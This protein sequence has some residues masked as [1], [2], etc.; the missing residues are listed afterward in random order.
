MT[1][2]RETGR[3]CLGAAESLKHV[4]CCARSL[5]SEI[6]KRAPDRSWRLHVCIDQNNVWWI[7]TWMLGV[8]RGG[9]FLYWRQKSSGKMAQHPP[10]ENTCAL[11]QLYML[12]VTWAEWNHSLVLMADNLSIR[13]A[14]YWLWH[15][16]KAKYTNWMYLFPILFLFYSVLRWYCIE[17]SFN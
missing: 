1:A 11:C 17:C 13:D 2:Q 7:K 9:G 12:T 5:Q 3:L 8:R 4:C 15:N 16:S 14:I 10:T 6:W